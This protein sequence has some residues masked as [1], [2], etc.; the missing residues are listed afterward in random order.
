[1]VELDVQRTEMTYTALARIEAASGEP[2][3]ALD[4]VKRLIDERLT[5]KLRTFAPALHAFC[6]KGDIEGA[7]EAEAEIANAGIEIS[8]AEYGALLV[9]YA[10][11]ERWEDGLALL[12]RM[13]EE[14][15]T[16]SYTHLTLPTTP[17]V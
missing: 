12:R 6:M 1:M 4:V 14:I 9:A 3:R 15:R 17:Y 5:P 2:R 11:A 13:R 16:V 7:L 10:D 8:E